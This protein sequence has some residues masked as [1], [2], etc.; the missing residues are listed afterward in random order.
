MRL[1]AGINNLGNRAYCL[2][3]RV[4]ALNEGSNTPQ[5]CVNE[6][7]IGCYSAPGRD[8]RMTFA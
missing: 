4:R 1:T 8:T 5:G 6:Q 3:Q 2:W 7:G